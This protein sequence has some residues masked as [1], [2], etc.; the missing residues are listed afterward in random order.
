MFLEILFLVLIVFAVLMVSYKGAMSEF[1][2][3]QKEWAP[4]IDWSSLLAEGFPL[5][6]R[7]V[8]PEWMGNWNVGNTGK[9]WPVLVEKDGQ[10]LHTKWSD[11]A[12]SGAKQP[13]IEN[14]SELAEVV[15]LPVAITN[16][17]DGGFRRWSWLPAGLTRSHVHILGPAEDADVWNVEKT[18][19]ACTLIQSTDGLPLMIWLAHEGAVPASV[20]PNLAGKNPWSLKSS[21]IPWMEEVKFV[22]VKLRPGNALAIPA[23][24]WWAARP[25]LPPVCNGEERMMDGAWFWITEFQTPISAIVSS[26]SAGAQAGTGAGKKMMRSSEIISPQ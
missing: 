22:E 23:H 2:I 14:G 3:L 26:A 11:W 9:S 5:V 16:W 21:Q 24:W 7:N 13:L 25:A 12:K 15:K 8:D 17:M 19:A 1:Q 4:N 18:R 6:I 20:A 10:I